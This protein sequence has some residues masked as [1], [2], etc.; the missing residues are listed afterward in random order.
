MFYFFRSRRTWKPNVQTKRIFSLGLDRYIRM[1]LT[2]HALRCIDKA[3]GLDEYLLTTPEHKLDNDLA[4]EWRAKIA[5]VYQKLYSLE[6]ATLNVKPG[7]ES[8]VPR[9]LQARQRGLTLEQLKE[10]EAHMAEIAL[11]APHAS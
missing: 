5:A 7:M 10:L 4:C 6:V 3:G 9:H 11:D 2:M 1:S 8:Q